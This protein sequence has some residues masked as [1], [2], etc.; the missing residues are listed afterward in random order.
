MGSHPSQQS[1][2]VQGCHYV[3]AKA[4]RASKA[5]RGTKE[6][7]GGGRSG[8]RSG[9]REEAELRTETRDSMKNALGL[10]LFYFY[11]CLWSL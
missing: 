2:K 10:K 5:Q 7:R 6:G 4:T 1:I 11:L 9:G 3:T 8:G